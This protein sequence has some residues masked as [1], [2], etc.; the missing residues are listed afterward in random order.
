MGLQTNL[1]DLTGALG[2]ASPTW[3]DSQRDPLRFTII[4]LP[5]W[6][7]NILDHS[8]EKNHQS[9]H[10]FSLPISVIGITGLHSSLVSWICVR[11]LQKN[12]LDVPYRFRNLWFSHCENTESSSANWV[13]LS[14]PSPSVFPG[15]GRF[16]LRP[17]RLHRRSPQTSAWANGRSKNRRW[18][19]IVPAKNTGFIDE[20]WPWCGEQEERNSE[21][22]HAMKN[23]ISMEF[24]LWC[25]GFCDIGRRRGKVEEN[26]QLRLCGFLWK[27]WVPRVPPNSKGQTNCHFPSKPCC[28]T[29][30][31]TIHHP[32]GISSIW[33]HQHGLVTGYWFVGTWIR[34]PIGRKV[35]MLR[36]PV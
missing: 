4:S 32:V 34:Q 17:R 2:E 27:W 30:E 31:K 35:P 29:V 36:K 5:L 1:T 10:F 13:K 20:F 18:M 15:Y 26:K 21:K 28:L 14:I 11:H 3:R 16:P 23:D 7:Y 24:D 33:N 25:E 9:S 22:T 8:P 6:N 19:V 12:Y